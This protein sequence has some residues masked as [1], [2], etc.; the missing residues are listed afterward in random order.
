MSVLKL[1]FAVFALIGAIDRITG[2]HLKL[3]D[4]FEKGIISAGPLALAMA[5][6]ITVAPV[7]STVLAPILTPVA[8]FLHI[9]LSFIAGF[10]AND[11]GGASIADELSK[12]ALWGGFNGLVVAS[13]MG[14]TIC[15]T[16]PIALNTIDAK[17]HREVLNGILCGVA[18]IPVGCLVSGLFMGYNLLSLLLN[19]LPVIIVSVIT[20]IG[21]IVNPVLCRKIFNIIGKGIVIVITLGLAAGIF[22]HITGYVLIPGMAPVMDGFKTV[23]DIA[24]ILAGIFPL[25]NVVSRIFG[26]VFTKIGKSIKINDA[27]VLGLIASLANSLPMFDLIEKMNVKGRIMNMAFAVSASFVFGDHLAF[28]MAFNENYVAGMVIGKLVGGVSALV[29]AHFLYKFTYKE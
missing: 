14:V 19:L 24:I 23:C 18:T 25:I 5:G 11:M 7:I 22:T 15:F 16:V 27:S 10:V 26:R 12:S 20:S 3:G 1:I 29:V 4:E 8:D 9:D 13:M 6:M 21:L 2:K 28:T 17:Y